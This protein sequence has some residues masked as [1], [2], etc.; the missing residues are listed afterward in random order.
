MRYK[1]PKGHSSCKL[2]AMLLHLP[3]PIYIIER[4]WDQVQCQMKISKTWKL[5]AAG[6]GDGY[7][8]V[9]LQFCDGFKSQV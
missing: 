1:V 6:E 3:A 8:T 4:F 9:F 7:V 2:I 5:P